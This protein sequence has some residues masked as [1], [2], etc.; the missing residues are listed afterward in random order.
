MSSFASGTVMRIKINN[1]IE[2]ALYK[3]KA[4]LFLTGV[5]EYNVL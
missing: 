4:S 1:A 5:D 3:Y 2:N